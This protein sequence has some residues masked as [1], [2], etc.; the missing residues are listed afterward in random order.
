MARGERPWARPRG[1]CVGFCLRRGRGSR[2]GE[3]EKSECACPLLL[4][5][6]TWSI[7]AAR[8][9][10]PPTVQSI[11]MSESIEGGIIKEEEEEERSY[12]EVEMF[13]REEIEA[14][15][16]ME[17][18]ERDGK[19]KEKEM[20]KEKEKEMDYDGMEEWFRLNAKECAAV[21]DEAVRKSSG[22]GWREGAEE[23]LAR[24]AAEH[25]TCDL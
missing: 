19:E 17:G 22:G 8:T 12:E 23:L 7:P 2:G 20:E 3:V 25:L 21:M 1:N 16:A 9:R 4:C 18:W 24:Q 11:A 14:I 15:A 10:P 5:A 13:S 6:C